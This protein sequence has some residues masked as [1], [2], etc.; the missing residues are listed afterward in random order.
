MPEEIDLDEM[1]EEEEEVEEE[2]EEEEEPEE[3]TPE[4]PS[5]PTER[6]K[7]KR[8]ELYE[9]E[10]GEVKRLR[11]SCPRCGAGIFLADHGERLACG[12]CG[13]T[14]FKQSS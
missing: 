9:T 1:E 13:Y 2:E 8:Y 7:S 14:E 3:P 5:Q 4:E 11:K 6:D 12:K 10:G